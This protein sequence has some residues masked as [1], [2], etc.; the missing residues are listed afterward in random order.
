MNRCKNCRKETKNKSY[1]SV[2]CRNKGYEGKKRA[3]YVT[4]SCHS[5]KKEFE[6]KKQLVD[7][8]KKYCSVECQHKG[9]KVQ[10]NERI[11]LN[12]LFCGSEFEDL[13]RFGKKEGVQ[14]KYC[15]RKCKDT[16]QKELYQGEGNPVYGQEHSEE[17]KKWQSDRVTKMWES[18]EHRQKVQKGQEKFRKY[19]GHWCGT[20]E[21]SK[22]RRRETYL[23]Q[24]GVDHNW[25]VKEIREKCEI[26]SIKNTGLT[27]HERA[28]KALLR[29]K[30]TTIETK[31]KEILI[32][33]NIDFKKNFYITFDGKMRAYDFYL[34]NY[35][36]LIEADGDYW[37][38]N[39]NNFTT[40]NEAQQKNRL[41]DDFKNK[42]AKELGYNLV[43]FWETDINKNEFENVFLKEIKRWEIR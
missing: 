21:D 2:N 37:H 13:K 39:P 31:I 33:N 34:K 29:K 3:E 8:G 23:E 9:Y 17:W 10:K 28:R 6:A 4:I 11:K 30:E 1:C 26:T 19:N 15:S 5:C 38:S 7:G 24:Y 16:H 20:D 25:K 41:N 40:L 27:T 36:L 32:N 14:K 22:N 43:R 35:N 42:I 18:E 12:C